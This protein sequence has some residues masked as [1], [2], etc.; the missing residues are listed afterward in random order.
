MRDPNYNNRMVITES[1]SPPAMADS[2]F[3][4]IAHVY[5]VLGNATRLRLL[6]AL[7]S[8]SLSFTELM[9]TLDLNPKT[10][11]SGLNLMG[12]C[13]LIRKSYPHQVYVITPL[14]R[15]VIREQVLALQES[16]QPLPGFEG[17]PS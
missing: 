1:S 11:S 13:G 14:G 17:R 4:T 12:K 10:L 16:L 15:R 5:K 3:E 2:G 6:H 7:E 9:K 8:S